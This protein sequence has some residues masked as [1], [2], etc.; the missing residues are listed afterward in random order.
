MPG[1]LL[2]GTSTVLVVESGNSCVG[3][4]SGDPSAVGRDVE[5][6]NASVASAPGFRS[7]GRLTVLVTNDPGLRVSCAVG[8]AVIAVDAV[9]VNGRFCVLG[10]PW[11]RCSSCRS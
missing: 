1:P 5:R 4:P 11:R 3:V 8:G 2:S 7:I 6:A 10:A 9:I